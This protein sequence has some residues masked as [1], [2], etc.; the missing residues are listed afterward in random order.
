MGYRSDVRM[1]VQGPKE[2]I[3][4]GF[5]ALVLTGNKAMHDAV[6]EWLI[7]DDGEQKTV[8]EPDVPLAV[9]ILGKGGTDWKWYAGYEDVDAHEAIFR[10]FAELYDGF[11]NERPYNLLAGAFVRIGEDEDEADI[12]SRYWGDEG[13]EL[14]GTS[15][16]VECPYDDMNKPD[17][18]ESLSQA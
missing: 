1:V 3:L 9:A 10:H 4:T 15:R 17:L 6:G 5:G 2:L 8:G 7:M 16:R 12:K 11:P 18:R 14:A 13:Y